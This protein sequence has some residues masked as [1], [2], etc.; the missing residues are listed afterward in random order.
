MQNTD[1]AKLFWRKLKE[2]IKT[3]K[4]KTMDAA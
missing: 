3:T 2:K 1:C 4:R